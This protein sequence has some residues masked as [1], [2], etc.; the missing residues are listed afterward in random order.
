MW[1]LITFLIVVVVVI[2]NHNMHIIMQYDVLFIDYLLLTTLFL[3]SN[4]YVF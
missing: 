4:L 3:K 2:N 1:L